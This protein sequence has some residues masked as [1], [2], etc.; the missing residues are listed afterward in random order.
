MVKDMLW[1]S[2]WTL[3][4]SGGF[5]KKCSKQPHCVGASYFSG[6]GHLFLWLLA[7]LSQCGPVR[8]QCLTLC[9]HSSC[10]VILSPFVAS[11]PSN[12]F[13][14]RKT[15]RFHE[16]INQTTDVTSAQLEDLRIKQGPSTRS[17]G[18]KLV[19]NVNSVAP[20]QIYWINSSEIQTQQP[21]LKKNPVSLRVTARGGG[22]KDINKRAFL[23]NLAH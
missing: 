18:R 2:Y 5:Q 7:S 1:I 19:R 20:T 16:N 6:G 22:P 23:E 9:G 3:R 12:C 14:L 11:R 8:V 13:W 15:W 10:W 17:I 21:A 4:S